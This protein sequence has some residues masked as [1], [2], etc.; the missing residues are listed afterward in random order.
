[1]SSIVMSK[2]I[3]FYVY[4]TDGMMYVS[5]FHSVQKEMFQIVWERRV[6]TGRHHDS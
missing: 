2:I 4:F 3:V 6:P 5:G 1:M